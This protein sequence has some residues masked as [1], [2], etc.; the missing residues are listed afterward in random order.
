MPLSFLYR[1]CSFTATHFLSLCLQSEV[2][3]PPDGRWLWS[4]R[5]PLFFP[6]AVP[7]RRFPERPRAHIHC[8]L[9]RFLHEGG[10]M[11][12]CP[13]PAPVLRAYRGEERH[14]PCQRF[15]LNSRFFS[16]QA[17]RCQTCNPAFPK[18]VFFQDTVEAA[19]NFLSGYSLPAADSHCQIPGG[20]KTGDGK[21]LL[22]RVRRNYNPAF[23]LPGILLSF[24]EKESAKKAIPLPRKFRC[25]ILLF[26]P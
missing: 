26:S 2:S 17:D 18:A 25:K 21:Y 3:E 6:P 12:R 9:H 15:F 24:S 11:E 23:R 4:H 20:K 14:L 22:I 10:T 7:R 19:G 5:C 13:V 8:P 1:N 16:L